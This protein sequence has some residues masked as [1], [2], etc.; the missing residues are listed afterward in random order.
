MHTDTPIIIIIKH[1]PIFCANWLTHAR[2]NANEMKVCATA[3]VCSKSSRRRCVLI[4]FSYMSSF[5]YRH[6]KQH[7]NF[8]LLCVLDSVFFHSHFVHSLD[9]LQSVATAAAAVAF[10]IFECQLH[11]FIGCADF[12]IQRVLEYA[13]RNY[14]LGVSMPFI[15]CC[16]LHTNHPTAHEIA[17]GKLIHTHTR[18]K[19][20]ER[21]RV[22][23]K[24]WTVR[25]TLLTQ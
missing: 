4:F 3:S 13:V 21:E 20:I 8:L 17:G 7:K 1:R 18:R 23:A 5:I 22:E 6:N 24:N 10:D 25:C 14:I 2:S 19:K 11:I 15:P 12:R 9:Y 16:T